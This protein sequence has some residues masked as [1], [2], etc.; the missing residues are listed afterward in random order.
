MIPSSAYRCRNVSTPS[1]PVDVDVLALLVCLV[2]ELW[3]DPEGVRSEV[4]TLCLQEIGGQVLR[5]V[6]IVEA[7]S[8]AEGGCGNAPES[9][10]GN[11]AGHSLIWLTYTQSSETYSLH[12]ACAL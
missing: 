1:G 6:S 5:P 8:G 10:L 2:G 12:P 4:I 7:Q 11:S 3:L 9:T